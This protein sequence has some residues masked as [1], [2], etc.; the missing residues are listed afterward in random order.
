M[1]KQTRVS[2]I[3][4]YVSDG[5]DSTDHIVEIDPDCR[6]LMIECE[7]HRFNFIRSHAESM[8]LRL[9]NKDGNPATVEDVI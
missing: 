5:D 9:V 6:E 1:K 4:V 8:G 7:L 3:D 2:G